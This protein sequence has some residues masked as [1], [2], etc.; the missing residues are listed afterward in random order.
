[1]VKTNKVLEYGLEAAR[2]D[3]ILTEQKLVISAATS[4]KRRQLFSMF[5]VLYSKNRLFFASL[6][7]SR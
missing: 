6:G 4:D 2:V 5:E 1:M 7:V 3:R